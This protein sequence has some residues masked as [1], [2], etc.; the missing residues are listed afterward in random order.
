MDLKTH[1][2]ELCAVNSL[3]IPES[4]KTSEIGICTHIINTKSVN[5]QDK[6]GQTALFWGAY[7]KN[8]SVCQNLIESGADVNLQAKNGTSPLYVAAQN[9]HTDV[10]SI[11]LKEGAKLDLQTKDGW[12]P[13]HSAAIKG[14][15]DVCSILL[16]AGAKL[17]LQENVSVTNIINKGCYIIQ[18][19][20]KK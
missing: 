19:D 6:H 1:L 13:L 15:T 3:K 9:G 7:Y 5:I 17:D 18:C 16:K 4:A 12:T 14:H 10:C 2:I 8:V 11:L 20:L